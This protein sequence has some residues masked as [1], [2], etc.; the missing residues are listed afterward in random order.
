MAAA[1]ILLI[2]IASALLAPILSQWV[3]HNTATQQDLSNALAQPSATHWLGTDQL[4]RDT[5]TRLLF[6]AQVSLGVAALTM[7][8]SLTLGTAVGLLAGYLGGWIDNVLMRLL[9][10]LLAVPPIF[11]FIMLSIILRPNALTLAILISSISWLPVAR[12]V[13]AQVLA[14]KHLEYIVAV[15]TL[16]ATGGRVVFRHI[17]PAVAPVLIVTASL[18]MGQIILIEAA[19]DFLGLGLR[20]PAP[21]W[22][23]MISDAQLAITHSALPAI[24][25]GATIFIAVLATNVLGDALRDALD[26]TL[27]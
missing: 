23:N 24:F 20:P 10:M 26:P 16:G 15:Q 8:M 18:S 19:L 2:L 12:L 5:L 6:G 7:G 14:T 21:S 3:T 22:G 11:F 9:D 4:G 1:L 25:P 17:L 13:R 27:Q